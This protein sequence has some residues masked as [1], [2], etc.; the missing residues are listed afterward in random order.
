MLGHY[1]SL[2]LPVAVDATEGHKVYK[3][4]RTEPAIYA[5]GSLEVSVDVLSFYETGTLS[6]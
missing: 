6:I 2:L 4:L 1:A 5:N 3:M